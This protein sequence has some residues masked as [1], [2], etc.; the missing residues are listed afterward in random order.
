MYHTMFMLVLLYLVWFVFADGFFKSGE[1]YSKVWRS[2]TQRRT[3]KTNE[4]VLD[5]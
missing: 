1:Y 3:N 4:A 2:L 5:K